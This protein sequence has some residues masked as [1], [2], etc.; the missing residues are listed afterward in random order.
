M[1]TYTVTAVNGTTPK[2][3]TGYGLMQEINLDLSDGTQT[4]RGVNW[5]TKAATPLPQQGESIDFEITE[6][7]RWG[8]K[9][10]KPKNPAYA[11]GGGGAPKS[12]GGS[13]GGMSPD[14]EKKIVRQHS[15]AQ[16]IAFLTATQK[17]GFKLADVKTVTDWFDN[18]VFG[19][20][21]QTLEQALADLPVGGSVSVEVPIQENEFDKVPF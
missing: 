4:Y 20:E 8:L 3:D 10:K 1:P 7:P 9:A 17:D 11:N 21:P 18:D 12:F 6:D 19:T 5:F 14:R 16:A 13:G 15:Q 2:P